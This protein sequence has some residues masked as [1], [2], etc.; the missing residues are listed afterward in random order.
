M[1]QARQ[2]DLFPH[3]RLQ[4]PRRALQA[5][6]RPR[7][8]VLEE[9]EERRLIR[10]LLELSQ[11]AVELASAVVPRHEQFAGAAPERPGE[12]RVDGLDVGDCPYR[13]LLCLP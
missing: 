3:P 2:G 13:L 4:R 9:V 6:A 12:V 1:E 11:L 7:K 8:A 5:M 10:H